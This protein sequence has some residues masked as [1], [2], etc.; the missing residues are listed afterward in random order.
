MGAGAAARRPAPHRGVRVF[1]HRRVRL[2]A[3]LAVPVLLVVLQGVALWR[4]F[5]GPLESLFRDYAGTPKS[6]TVPWAGLVLALV[7]I[8]NR[9]R[10]IALAAAVAIDLVY[11]GV[12]LA[13]GGPFAVGNGPVLVLT[14]LA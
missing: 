2:V 4:G 3:V 12:R 7:G 5:E 8:G 9:H 10:V 11:A 1:A 6:M 14:G 13:L